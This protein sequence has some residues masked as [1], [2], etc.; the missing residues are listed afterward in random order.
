MRG[1]QT[2]LYD[3]LQQPPKPKA[4]GKGRNK[5]LDR[6]R[7][8]LIACRYY[9]YHILNEKRYDV[10]IKNL[11]DEFLLSETRIIKLLQESY[12]DF[13]RELKLNNTTVRVLRKKYPFLV[14]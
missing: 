13:L 3:L 9:Y 14:W 1:Q 2:L 12:R 11:S 6:R 10:T 8:E 7:G 4:E 5:G